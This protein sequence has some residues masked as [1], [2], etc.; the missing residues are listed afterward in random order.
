[1]TH[2]GKL[3]LR[4]AVDLAYTNKHLSQASDQDVTE[5]KAC[6]LSS[7]GHCSWKVCAD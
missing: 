7:P 1:M 3:R 5:S 4:E 2:T 6:I